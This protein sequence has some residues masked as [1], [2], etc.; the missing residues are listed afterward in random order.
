MELIET[1]NLGFKKHYPTLSFIFGGLALTFS[2]CVP[3]VFLLYELSNFWPVFSIPYV[4]NN[5]ALIF[6]HLTIKN[7]LN[8][9][10]G[11]FGFIAGIVSL[12]VHRWM[13][14]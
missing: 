13:P 12:H 7:K 5:L 9:F 3:V 11:Y 6:G 1:E 8:W 14:K 4:F 10:D 2:I